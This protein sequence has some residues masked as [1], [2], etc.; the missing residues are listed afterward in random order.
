MLSICKN[1]SHSQILGAQCNHLGAVFDINT[2]FRKLFNANTDFRIF[3]D[4]NANFIMSRLPL[5]AMGEILN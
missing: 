5:A 4:I 2:D 1:Y 3:F